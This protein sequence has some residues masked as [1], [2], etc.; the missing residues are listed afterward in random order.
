M[1]NKS[2]KLDNARQQKTREGDPSDP[3]CWASK[4]LLSLF[5]RQRA[6]GNDWCTWGY[7]LLQSLWVDSPDVWRQFFLGFFS[8]RICIFMLHSIKDNKGWIP[9]HYRPANG[10]VIVA[11]LDV[12]FFDLHRVW[13]GIHQL[14]ILGWHTSC[15]TWSAHAWKACQRMPSETSIPAY[16]LMMIGTGTTNG[17]M[18]MWTKNN[19]VRIARCITARSSPCS[20]MALT[21]GESVERVRDFW[22]LAYHDKSCVAG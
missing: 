18:Y 15:L 21:V 2:Q 6:Q 9:Q 22:T 12:P 14:S 8:T 1:K 13:G 17:V 19:A 4:V 16:I 5:I 11:N 20:R 3:I 7:T 10:K